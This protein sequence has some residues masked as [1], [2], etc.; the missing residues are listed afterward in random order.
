MNYK[1]NISSRK[2]AL[3]KLLDVIIKHENE[4][5]QALYDDF[6]KPPFESI[7]TE[8]SYVISELKDT[9]KTLGNGQKLEKYFLQCLI[10]RQ[11]IIS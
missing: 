7:A 5:I 10:S 2:E 8:T 3:I 6:K 1:L 11:P 9:I 4:I